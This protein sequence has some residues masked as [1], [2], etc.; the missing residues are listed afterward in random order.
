M[1]EKWGIC[2]RNVSIPALV[3][4]VLLSLSS[5]CQ[6]AAPPPA[7]LLVPPKAPAQ[8]QPADP[9]ALPEPDPAPEPQPA[10]EPEPVPAPEPAE[11]PVSDNKELYILMYHHFV[12]EGQE[13]NPW[14]LTPSRFREDMQWLAGHGYTTVLPSEVIRGD[15][16][17]ERA[18]MLTFDDGYRS[19]YELAYPI[20]QEFR[21]KAVISIITHWV[22]DGDPGYLTWEQCRE[23]AESGLVEFGSHTHASHA[24][25]I[26]RAGGETR[27]EY[28]NRVFPDIQKS[29]ALIED[30]TGM[31]VQFFAY[32][33]GR[34]E[35]WAAGF[36][37]EKFKM[38]VTTRH[39][40]ADI[41]EGLY[42]LNRCNISMEEPVWKFL[43]A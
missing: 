30:N 12:P 34:T 5:A 4:S 28:E 36:L 8:S 27:E 13:C 14:M 33:N 35:K 31:P 32:P 2:V 37:R 6:R 10:L 17:P 16:L 3:L 41:S 23:M 26:T 7:A 21:V 40:P 11:K 18:V 22:E 25:G 38:T 24:D 43:P 20:L 42:D 1:R 15:P 39:G 19:N 29:V 9:G